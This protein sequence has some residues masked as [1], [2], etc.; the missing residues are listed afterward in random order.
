MGK[1][2]VALFAKLQVA[3]TPRTIDNTK[4]H[5]L[6]P[7]CKLTLHYGSSCLLTKTKN[8]ASFKF[9]IKKTLN[10]KLLN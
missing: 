4:V 7:V 9:F 1:S 8:K 3:P 2:K 6:D 5:S 10:P